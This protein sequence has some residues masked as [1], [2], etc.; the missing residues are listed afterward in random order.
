HNQND[1]FSIS[2][3]TILSMFFDSKKRLWVGTQ[4]GGL[5]LYDRA[6]D[7]FYAITTNDGLANN[8]VH[9]IQEDQSGNLWVSTNK[10]MSNIIFSEFSVP[11]KPEM[12]NIMN[13][14]VADGL[15]SNQF[16]GAAAM[17]EQGE[18]LFGGIN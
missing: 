4:G 14:T 12:F 6:S 3:N 9:A 5:N 7:R 10:G 15:Q 16:T 17:N 2:D 1:P 18:L 13:Y 11:V 8:V